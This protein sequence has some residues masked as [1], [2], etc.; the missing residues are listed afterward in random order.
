MMPELRDDALELQHLG[1]QLAGVLLVRPGLGREGQVLGP[2]PPDLGDLDRDPGVVGQ[3]P[4][5][6]QA[7]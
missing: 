4:H 5:Q 7:P 6:D 3:D 2:Q 1:L